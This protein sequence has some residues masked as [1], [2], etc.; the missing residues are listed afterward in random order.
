MVLLIH[1][2]QAADAEWLRLHPLWF[3]AAPGVFH[4]DPHPV[5]AIVIGKIAQNKDAGMIHL[6]DG[7]DALGGAEP[8]YGDIGG[9]RHR[10]AVKCHHTKHMSG[11]GKA[12]RL[13]GA[14]VQHVKEHALAL[15]HADRLAGTQHLS[16]DAEQ[17]IADF[18]P[19][20]RA[21]GLLTGFLA[22]L[23]IKV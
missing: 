11:E 12:S 8:K 7:R 15:L 17:R 9:R 10:I 16:V 13:G 22:F 1:H 19:L 5:A 20:G 18:E 2:R 6:H 21:L 4:Y 3:A 23:K 14:R